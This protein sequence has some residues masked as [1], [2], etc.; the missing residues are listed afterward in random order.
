MPLADVSPAATT[1]VA[2]VLGGGQSRRFGADKLDADLG[3]GSLLEHALA[4]LPADADLIV[5]GPPRAVHRPARFVSEEPAGTGPAAAIIAGLN[6]ALESTPDAI[7][8]LPG[9]APAA[10]AAAMILLAALNAD[11]EAS[12]MMATDGAGREQPLQLALR[13]AAAAALI[14]AAGE[15]RGAGLSARGLLG[16]LRPAPRTITLAAAEHFDVDTVEDLHS[17]QLRNADEA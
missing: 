6:A 15:A 8:V 5:V 17:W 11:P 13:P 12:I 14:A 4:G 1:L 9:D 10:G 3:A 2:V 16:R 7:V